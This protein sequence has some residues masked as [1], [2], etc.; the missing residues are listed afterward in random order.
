ML[1]ISSK[2]RRRNARKPVLRHR[3]CDKRDKREADFHRAITMHKKSDKLASEIIE[4]KK[5]GGK[6]A[7]KKPSTSVS[8]LRRLR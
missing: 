8:A 1:K 5:I 4:L 3:D 7:K 2:R 6:K